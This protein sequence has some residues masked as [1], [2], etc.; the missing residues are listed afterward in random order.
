MSSHLDD[1]RAAREARDAAIEAYEN[2]V[3]S[4]LEAGIASRAVGS[5]AGMSHQGCLKLWTRRET[6]T[7]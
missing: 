2:A 7:P 1:L 3:V 4:A 6:V 5:A